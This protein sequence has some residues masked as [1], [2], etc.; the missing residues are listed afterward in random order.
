M[1][2][3]KLPPDARWPLVCAVAGTVVSALVFGQNRLAMFALA[4]GGL[5][6]G[7]IVNALTKKS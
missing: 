3:G 7:F 5:I 4:F 2:R 1:V 6:A